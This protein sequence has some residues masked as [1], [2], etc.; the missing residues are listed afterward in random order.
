MAS[1][2]TAASRTWLGGRHS[3]DQGLRL[4]VTRH[5]RKPSAVSNRRSR[6]S[7]VVPAALVICTLAGCTDTARI[8]AQTSSTTAVT[9]AEE[10]HTH[11]DVLFARDIIEHSAQAVALSNLIIGS[12]NAAPQVTDVARQITATSTRRIDESQALLLDWGFAP[13]TI[14]STPP[15]AVPGAPVEPGEHPVAS[16]AD[17]RR[18]RDAAGSQATDVFFELMIRQHQFAISAARDQLQIGLHPRAMAIARSLIDDQ[19][20]EIY[21]MESLRR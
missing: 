7:F 3:C 10:A 21:T 17:F 4:G 19:Q 15:V 1:H 13:M 6:S 9:I 14:S 12:G 8:S 2:K 11:V 20:G 18:L 5:A 16:D